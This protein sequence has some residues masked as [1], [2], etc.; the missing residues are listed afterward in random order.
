MN[1][2]VRI[3]EP[4]ED[5]SEISE[6]ESEASKNKKKRVT[7]IVKKKVVM[8]EEEKQKTEQV[9]RKKSI[10]G[11]GEPK[12]ETKTLKD[13]KTAK[14]KS[15][16]IEPEVQ[17]PGVFPKIKLK[18]SETVKRP[19]EKAD[20][21]VVQLVHHD[22]EMVPQEPQEEMKTSVKITAV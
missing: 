5:I 2:I 20:M 14:K 16:K 6:S 8:D 21:E 17:E 9:S 12:E 13:L 22:F 15:S 3:S 11:V 4:L 18:K 19:I 10:Q 1:S 7:K